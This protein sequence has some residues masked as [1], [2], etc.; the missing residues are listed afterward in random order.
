MQVALANPNL[1]SLAAGFVD[2]ESLPVEEV[3]AAL[4][5]LLAD[6]KHAK[7]ALQ[8]GTTQGHPA[9][10]DWIIQ[11]VAKLD[12]TTPEAMHLSRK[13][14]IVTTGSQQL[15]YLLS[16]TLLDSGDIVITES[17]S[18]FVFHSVLA[19]VGVNVLTIPMDEEGMDTQEL[20]RTLE[21]IERA[22]E[23]HRVK[24][25]Y[26]VNYFQNPTG[27]SLSERRRKELMSTVQKVAQSSQQRIL[28]LEDAA[29]RELRYEGD[30]LPSLRSLD[31]HGQH[32]IYAGTFSKPLSPG[33][34]TGYAL[35]PQ[36]LLEPLLRLK[37]NH[38]FGSNN[39]SQNLLTEMVTSGAYAKHVEKLKGVYRE[40]RNA[41]V[42]SLEEHFGN[43]SGV[44]WTNPKGGMFVWLTLPPEVPT[45]PDSPFLK[46]SLKE[47]VLYIPGE[48]GH[49][50]DRGPVPTNEM[51]LSFGN[52]PID[53]IR[54]GIRRMRSAFDSVVQNQ[55]PAKV[56]G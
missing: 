8:Y 21:K 45:S 4:E 22:G 40:K 39:F 34:K 56:S 23:L 17:P 38:D 44:S 28:V 16:E 31:T 49:V 6:K 15:L 43:V 2:T 27:L 29:Y 12:N 25:I 47:G 26:T 11:H 46:A 52:A 19:G 37:G 1:I 30:E 54:E 9:L 24:L 13:N 55:Q 20:Q 10:L 7:F 42:G 14:V 32:V 48:F 36:D 18:Y 35:I 3:E 50:D 5:T 53:Q 51:R 33:L 41:L